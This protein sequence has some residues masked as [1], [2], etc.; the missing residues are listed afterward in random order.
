M[1]SPRHG[2][3]YIPFEQL[4]RLEKV[5]E[6]TYRSTALPFSPNGSGRAYGGHVYAQAVWAAANTVEAGFVIHNVTGFF[7]LA[8]DSSIPFIY[9]VQTIRNGRSYCTRLVNVT[10][11]EGDGIC[12][13]CTCSFKLPEESHFEVQEKIELDQKYGL[14]LSGK[15]PEDWAEVSGMDVPWYNSRRRL[16]GRNDAF[17]GL[18]CRKV[19]MTT[20][21]TSLSPFDRRQLFFYRAIGDLPPDP[22]MHAC[23][24]LYASDRNSLFIV[25][26]HFEISDRFTHMASL[27][28]T[29]VFHSPA[30]HIM[31]QDRSGKHW[32]SQ[33][34][35]T[36]RAGGGRATHH[37]RII[38][39]GGTH[40]AT[41]FQEGMIRVGLGENQ[42]EKAYKKSLERL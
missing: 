16:T 12:F 40:V 39:P 18:E 2:N 24:H 13:T 14:V 21:N 11:A 27:S 5:D 25:G 6:T 35:W 36:T 9:R 1:K 30:S 4:I 38:G 37:S 22:N 7:V 26:R 15:K 33:E 31:L 29:V 34:V 8:G 32:F 3:S 20:Y 28:H 17:P 10:Q 23:A 19:D 42:Y 41:T